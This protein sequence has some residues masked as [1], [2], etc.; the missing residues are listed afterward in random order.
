M[1]IKWIRIDDRLIHGQV[2]SSW[3]RYIGAEQI[4]CISDRAAT[5]PVQEQVLKMAAPGYIVHVFDVEKFIKI[6]QKKPIKKTT[7]LITDS[8]SSVLK[9]KNG[10]VEFSEVNYGGMRTRDDRTVIYDYDLCFTPEEDHDLHELID[11]GVK[12]NYQ[13]AAYDSPVPILDRIKQAGGK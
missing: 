8:T 13:I 3:L 6:Y 2:A 4:L 1:A 11:Q 9:M 10:G 7:F 5:N 12:I